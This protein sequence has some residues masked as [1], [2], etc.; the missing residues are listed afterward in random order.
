MRTQNEL[1]LE[2]IKKYGSITQLEALEHLGCMRLASR[3]NDLRRQGHLIVSET[4]R[5]QGK[6]GR[7]VTF[8]KYKLLEENVK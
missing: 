3:I 8:S 6:T 1:I 2:Y 5:Y 4:V 7:T